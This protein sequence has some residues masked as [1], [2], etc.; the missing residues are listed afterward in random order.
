MSSPLNIFEMQKTCQFQK[1]TDQPKLKDGSDKQIEQSEENI[2]PS[3]DA[4]DKK[5]K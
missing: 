2:I 4:E 5:G 3:K 1:I